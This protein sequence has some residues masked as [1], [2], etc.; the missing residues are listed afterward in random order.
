MPP[1]TLYLARVCYLPEKRQIG[2]QWQN[3]GNFYSERFPFF[4][5]LYISSLNVSKEGVEEALGTCNPK[6]VRWNWSAETACIQTATFEE[7]KKVGRL[8]EQS[9]SWN[10]RIAEPERQFLAEKNWSYGQGFQFEDGKAVP[11]Q[12]I[13]APRMAVEAWVNDFR[14]TL[15]TADQKLQEELLQEFACSYWL[16]VPLLEAPKSLTDKMDF[17]TENELFCYQQPSNRAPVHSH[18]QSIPRSPSAEQFLHYNLGSDTIDCECCSN[19]NSN[20]L[21]YSLWECAILQDSVYFESDHSGFALEFHR[22]HPQTAL[23]REKW[24]K[25][26]SLSTLPVGPLAEG[27]HVL[28]PQSDAFKLERAGKVNVLKE[29]ERHWHCVQNASALAN[30]IQS[31][32][33]TLAYLGRERQEVEVRESQKSL[34]SILLLSN[35][36]DYQLANAVQQAGRKIF[37]LLPSHCQNAQSAFF[38]PALARAVESIARTPALAPPKTAPNPS[39]SASFFRPALQSTARA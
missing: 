14:S 21:P 38:D 33:Q 12:Q 39:I 10:V 15:E 24:K 25:T 28:L 6:S 22:Q 32:N 9:F 34:T 31:L 18:I 5:K 27:E 7:L 3:G 37:E 23:Q 8:L 30:A 17:W 1:G 4:P 26:W 13:E 16:K 2:C 35:S 20:S 19:E 11:L 29:K 36:L